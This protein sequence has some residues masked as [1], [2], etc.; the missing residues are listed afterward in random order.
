METIYYLEGRGQSHIYHFYVLLLGGLYYI[1][2]NIKHDVPGSK[3]VKF[4]DRTKITNLRPEISFPVNINFSRGEI[5]NLTDFQLDAVKLIDHKV[6]FVDLKNLDNFQIIEEYGET[7]RNG[8]SD[9]P[10]VIYPFLRDLFLTSPNI[11]LKY[12]KKR[13]FI[14]RYGSEKNHQNVRKRCIINE[15]E[16]YD[17]LKPFN[18][19]YIQLE[20]Y[21]EKEKI[22]MFYGSEIIISTH[23]SGLT[24]SLFANEET[25]IIE[26]LNKGPRIG[27]PTGHYSFICEHLKL[28]YYRYKNIKEDEQGNVDIN[29]KEFIK[30]LNNF[31]FNN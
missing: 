6:N 13:I 15:K 23:S 7:C 22:E 9:N 2:N 30:Y 11:D 18:F 3:R 27:P 14:T 28:K 5:H 1:F 4:H 16:F 17:S 21:S 25:K 29:C 10:K 24:Y 19:E 26:I 8:Y 31:L 12:S 20:N